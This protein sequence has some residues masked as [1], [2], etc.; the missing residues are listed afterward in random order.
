MPRARVA[1]RAASLRR[2]SAT[3][4]SVRYTVAV[5][6]KQRQLSGSRLDM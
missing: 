1:R 3:L 5:A 4:L 2:V 6:R